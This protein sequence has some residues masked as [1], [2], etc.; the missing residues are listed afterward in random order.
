MRNHSKL[1]NCYL[2]T[3]LR[4]KGFF[5]NRKKVANEIVDRPNDY[6]IFEGVSTLTNVSRY[7]LPDPDVYRAFFKLHDLWEFPKA[8]DTCTYF[9]GCPHDKLD[10]AIAYDLA[11]VIGK[12][13]KEM[14]G[15]SLEPT[16]HGHHNQTHPA[17]NTTKH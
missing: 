2:R 11:E 9:K 15:I 7:D 10:L 13:K 5:S 12:F 1:V 14:A 16:P 8:E 3:Y 4:N 17:S 6:R